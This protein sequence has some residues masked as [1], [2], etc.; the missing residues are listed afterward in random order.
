MLIDQLAEEIKQAMKDK[1]K[2]KLNALRYLKAMLMENKVAAK[3][4][5]ETDVVVRLSKKIKETIESFPTGDGRRTQAQQELSYVES[6]LPKALTR[7]EVLLL[8]SNIQNKMSTPNLGAMMKELTPIIK[9]RFCGKEA[10]EL[11]KAALSAGK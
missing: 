10:T 5:D 11:V 7:E 8:I 9:G 6:Y 1:D 4:V 3:P 2:E